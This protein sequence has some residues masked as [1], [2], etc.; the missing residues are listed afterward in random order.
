MV[1]QITVYEAIIEMRRIT[2]NGG[3]FNFVH[4]TY[5]RDTMHTDGLR[6]AKRAKLRPAAKGDNVANAD[7]KLF[8]YDEYFHENRVCWQMLLMYFNGKKV[9][10]T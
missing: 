9:T 7:F 8:Y 1:E 3:T 2:A 6:E 4:C 10:L 5:N